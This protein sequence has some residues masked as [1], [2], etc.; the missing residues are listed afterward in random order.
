MYQEAYHQINRGR[1][2][3]MK[4]IAEMTYMG[5]V[6]TL[7]VPPFGVLRRPL[8]SV[9]SPEVLSALALG[10]INDEPDVVLNSNLGIKLGGVPACGM[11][12]ERYHELGV[13]CDLLKRKGNKPLYAV[14]G[15]LAPSLGVVL[16]NLGFSEGDLLISA[17]RV[18]EGEANSIEQARLF[19]Q[20]DEWGLYAHINVRRSGQRTG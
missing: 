2:A 6:G 15:E 5:L 20:Y 1:E 4:I 16:S 14:L 3:A 8:A 10:V 13:L 7:S 9:L 17:F 11:L 12:S 19:K 18:L